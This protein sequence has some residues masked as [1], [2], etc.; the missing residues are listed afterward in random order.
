M[1]IREVTKS[2]GF[3]PRKVQLLAKIKEVSKKDQ[4]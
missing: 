4:S 2:K 3:T 1:N